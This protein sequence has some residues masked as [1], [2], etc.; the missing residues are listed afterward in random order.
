MR[1]F[2]AGVAL[3][4][5]SWL[6]VPL[7]SNRFEPYD[8]SAGLYIGQ[9]LM[10]VAAFYFGYT[11]G[12]TSVLVFVAGAY[13]SLNLYPYVF[14]TSEARAWAILGLFMS[15]LLCVFPLAIGLLGKFFKKC[16][17]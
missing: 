14:G 4:A 15:L 7:V 8:S 17:Q 10:S 12:V 3:G 13:I 1:T 2:L 6:V 9:S 16:K 5:A 11:R